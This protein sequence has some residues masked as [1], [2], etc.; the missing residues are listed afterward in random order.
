MSIVLI[1]D[2]DHS[3]FACEQLAQQLRQ[4][5]QSCLTVAAAPQQHD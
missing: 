5:G 1:S 3:R 4:R 2:D